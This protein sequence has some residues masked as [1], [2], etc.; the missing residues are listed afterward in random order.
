MQKQNPGIADWLAIAGEEKAESIVS[1][2]P[3]STSTVLEIGCGTGAVLEALDRRGF[4]DQYWA[5]EPSTELYAQVQGQNISRLQG[6]ENTTLEHAFGDQTFDLAILSHVVEHLLAPA[7]LIY[8]ALS[9][10]S[11]VLVE[12]PIEGGPAGRARMAV[13]RTLGQDPYD[14]PAGHVQFFSRSSA[15]QLAGH[16]GGKVVAERGYFPIAP[17]SAQATSA[18]QKGVVAVAEVAEP[19]ARVYYEH[20]AMLLS[21]VTVNDWDHHYAKPQ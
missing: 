9:R 21:P 6:L 10:A 17:Y 16:S 15:R 13:K 2:A 1:L 3:K 14:N 8:E 11:C 20:F 19:V 4:A 12:V 18:L 5:C 7:T